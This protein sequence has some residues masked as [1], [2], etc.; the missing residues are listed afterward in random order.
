MYTQEKLVI[1]AN[2]FYVINIG[3]LM[4]NGNN[5]EMVFFYRSD[6]PLDRHETGYAPEL[7]ECSG[8][9]LIIC[10]ENGVT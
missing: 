6:N 9:F 2:S 7:F 10:E 4:K 5:K 8:M 1:P 3:Y